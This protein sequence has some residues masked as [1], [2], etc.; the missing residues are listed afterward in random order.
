MVKVRRGE[1][2]TSLQTLVKKSGLSQQNVR[3]ALKHLEK[4][5]FLTS[6][7]TNH[8]RLIKITNY[9]KH[10]DSSEREDCQSNKHLTSTQQAPNKHLTTIE[11]GKEGKEGEEVLAGKPADAPKRRQEKKTTHP[12]KDCQEVVAAYLQASGKGDSDIARDPGGWGR[13]VIEAD[14]LLAELGGRV[15]L[16]Q[17]CITERA[18]DWKGVSDWTMAGVAR[19]AKDWLAEKQAGAR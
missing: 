6:T 16:A 3:T 5:Q 7:P 12:H 2:V 18:K 17:E 19:R 10:Q 14:K 8:F 4:A 13:W 1:L 11:E 15:D 9:S